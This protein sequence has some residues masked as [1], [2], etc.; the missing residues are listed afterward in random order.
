MTQSEIK[1][2]RALKSSKQRKKKGLF[3][4]EGDKDVREV[5]NSKIELEYLFSSEEWFNTLDQGL[6]SSINDKWKEL[7]LKSI[8]QLS[9]FENSSGPIAV[10]NIPFLPDELVYPQNIFIYDKIRDPGNLGTIIRTADWF[11]ITHIFCSEDSVDLYNPKVLSA[12]KGSFTRI[13]VIYGNI[14]ELLAKLKDQKFKLF[15][16]SFNGIALSKIE[17]KGSKM[18]YVFGN[19]S[20]GLSNELISLC[21]ENVTIEKKGKAESLNLAMSSAIFMYNC[22]QISA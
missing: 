1:L 20:Q 19:E 2:I 18:A 22:S 11:D 13:N 9:Y 21:D 3:I 17:E 15:A 4:L 14:P 8:K 7:D 6:Q 12:S 5:L 16:T 10:C